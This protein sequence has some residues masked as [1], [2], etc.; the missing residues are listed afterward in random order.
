MAQ[1]VIY[2]SK[3]TLLLMDS[4]ILTFILIT[5]LHLFMVL[6]TNFTYLNITVYLAYILI[7]FD[8]PFKSLIY[9]WPF[10]SFFLTIC[11]RDSIL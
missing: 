7:V 10:C 1:N 6:I 3:S 4:S 2:L 11:L 8:M 5:V 9:R